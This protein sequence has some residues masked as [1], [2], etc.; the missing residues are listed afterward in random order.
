MPA[1]EYDLR[2]TV[3]RYVEVV[4]VHRL[5]ETCQAVINRGL[6]AESGDGGED[7]TCG[8]SPTYDECLTGAGDL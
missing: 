4:N 7:H 8:T 3:F 6:V 1:L 2:R 5:G